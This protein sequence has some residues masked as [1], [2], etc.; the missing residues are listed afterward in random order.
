MEERRT[1]TSVNGRTVS[2]SQ[3]LQYMH[4][5]QQWVAP[6]D[7]TNVIDMRAEVG[8]LT[9][10]IVFRGDTEGTTTADHWGGH[11]MAQGLCSLRISGAELYYMGQKD[12]LARYPIHMHLCGNALIPLVTVTLLRW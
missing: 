9:R 11:I 5:G 10:N 12:N 4:W 1:I 6:D 8:L 7:P 3:P 2:F